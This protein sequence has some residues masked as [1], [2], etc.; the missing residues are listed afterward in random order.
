MNDTERHR[1]YPT[2][3][4]AGRRWTVELPSG[5]QTTRTKRAAAELAATVLAN[6]RLQKAALEY[7]DRQDRAWR[8]R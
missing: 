4:K 1:A 3:T 2:I 8:R 6:Q 5:V 7:V